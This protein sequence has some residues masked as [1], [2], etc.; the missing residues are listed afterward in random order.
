MRTNY[1][2]LGTKW[3]QVSLNQAA[4]LM[5]MVTLYRE[6]AFLKRTASY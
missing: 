1:S 5:Q 2:N 3:M 6:G 4:P